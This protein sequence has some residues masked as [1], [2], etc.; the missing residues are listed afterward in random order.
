LQF[1]KEIM[2]QD[3]TELDFLPQ[4]RKERGR[5]LFER[6]LLSFGYPKIKGFELEVYPPWPDV[7]EDEILRL[8]ITSA[9]VVPV[10]VGW[11]GVLLV[12]EF[13]EDG[14]MR[15]EFP[16]GG[17]EP[18]DK[19]IIETATRELGEETGLRAIDDGLL[20]FRYARGTRKGRAG[21]QFIALIDG[22]GW[23]G[24]TD[25]SGRLFIPPFEGAIAGETL[26]MVVEPFRVF[27]DPSQSLL[28]YSKHPRAGASLMHDM[29]EKLGYLFEGFEG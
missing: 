17:V 29:S 9:G 20:P 25:D 22:T 16:S 5:F 14:S 19:S 12:R 7:Y 21:I 26:E 13:E 28:Q 8:K 4:L 3:R 27:F 24:R 2:T 6:S 18:E 10:V 11:R 23:K 1:I 15:W